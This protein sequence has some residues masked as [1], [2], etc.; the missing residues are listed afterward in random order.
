M[1]EKEDWKVGDRVQRSEW[2]DRKET[3]YA[4]ILTAVITATREKSRYNGFGYHSRPPETET[5]VDKVTVKWDDGEEETLDQWSVQPEDSE[6]EREFR[7]KAPDILDQIN[8]KLD[9]ANKYLSEAMDIAE[10]HGVP[11]S[12]GI[13]PLGQ[14]YMTRSFPSKWDGVSKEVVDSV[15]ETHAEYGDYYGWQHSAVCY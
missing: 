2:I 3:I 11:F 1:S 9:L 10:E 7:T 12:S 4:G 14:N 5:Y 8:E 15:T 6:L 13:S